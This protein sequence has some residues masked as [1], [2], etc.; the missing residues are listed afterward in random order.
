MTDAGNAPFDVYLFSE[1]FKRD[2]NTIIVHLLALRLQAVEGSEPDR[3][4][5]LVVPRVL[6]D[7]HNVAQDLRCLKMTSKNGI[8]RGPQ[9]HAVLLATA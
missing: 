7:A 2:L 4:K 1:I 6:H 8:A 9:I 3:P 5:E